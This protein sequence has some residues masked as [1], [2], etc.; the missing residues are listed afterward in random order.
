MRAISRE[1]RFT[2][3]DPAIRIWGAAEHNLKNVDVSI[4]LGRFVVVTGVSGSGKSTLVEQVLYNNYLSRTGGGGIP[5]TCKKIEGFEQIGAM[6]H[7]GQE[8]LTR[9]N[10]SNPATYLKI[11]DEIRRL[12]AATP[13]A[14]RLKIQPR[15]F[16]FNV[17]GGRC[18][19]CRGTGTVTIEMHFMADVEVSCDVCE[20][21]RF[22][23]HILGLNFQG[24]N[25]T[26]VLAQTVDEASSFFSGHSK[27]VKP[28]EILV[29][30]GLGYLQLGQATSTLSG[31][32][33]QRLKL[34]AFLLEDKSQTR[35]GDGTTPQ[36]PRLFLLDEPTTG[37]SSSDIK[38]LLRVINR[39]V[40]EGHTVVAIEHNLEFIAN[41][42][43]VI[44]LGPE[45]GDGGGKLVA[46]GTPLT[47]ATNK[48]S[49]TGK[50]LRALFGLPIDAG[51]G[52]LRS[53]MRKAAA[54]EMSG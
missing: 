36:L 12:F 3:R 27:I 19:K 18:E 26:R 17:A 25:I 1:R 13:D 7:M 4:P 38:N 22:Q 50:E 2:R 29:S 39:L 6:I 9:S 32:E 14:K 11:Y 48:E 53:V 20:G 45:G 51:V 42:E 43:Y 5:G 34:A 8:T 49:F 46:A 21:R 37:L 28:L 15:H 52:A 31:G 47:I 54:S 10:R 35:L 44:D 41:G 16:S 33:A 30:V 24:R 40:T 23:A